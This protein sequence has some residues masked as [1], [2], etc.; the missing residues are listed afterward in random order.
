[1][2]RD[3][4]HTCFGVFNSSDIICGGID[5]SFSRRV[6]VLQIPT[7]VNR[8]VDH[9]R[10][11]L[12]VII[13]PNQRFSSFVPVWTA[14]TSYR[15]TI[16]N[17]FAP[18]FKTRKRS[19][20]S[21]VAVAVTSSPVTSTTSSVLNRSAENPYSGAR[22]LRPPP[23]SNPVPTSLKGEEYQQR[24]FYELIAANLT[25]PPKGATPCDS[26]A[27]IASTQRTPGCSVMVSVAGL[28]VTLFIWENEMRMPSC[29]LVK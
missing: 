2:Q 21:F 27:A 3:A 24:S 17:L 22:K 20:Y 12:T 25:R 9:L 14:C 13:P 4:G 26:T 7:N 6:W 18:P 1:V 11:Q 28:Y 19:A 29:T 23:R 8:P 10:R 5:E 15:V 16:P